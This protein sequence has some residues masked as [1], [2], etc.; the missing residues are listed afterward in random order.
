MRDDRIIINADDFGLHRRCTDAIC[1]A[2]RKG[3]ITDST[4][5]TNGEAFD[6]AAE[7]IGTEHLEGRIGIHLNLTEGKPLTEAIKAFPGFTANGAFH[8]KINRTKPLTREEQRAVYEELSAQARRIEETGLAITHADS[9][10]HIH[11]GIF[12]AP[13]AARVCKEHG[14]CKIRLH[15]NIGAISPQKRMV[16]KLYNAWLHAQ[17]FTTTRFFGSMEDVE[18]DG[19]KDGLEIMVHPDFDGQGR[20]IDRTGEDGG[21][22]RGLP[23][24]LPHG[25]FRLFSYREL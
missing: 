19:L 12:I 25:D 20:L 24:F 21:E 16:K 1:E 8:G 22:A 3:L 14:I 13:I 7:R 6:Y 17:G 4:W 18:R 2:F 15:R 23:L 5:L 11:T 10:H 9:H